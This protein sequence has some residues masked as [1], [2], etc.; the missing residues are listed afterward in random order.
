MRPLFLTS[1]LFFIGCNEYDLNNNLGNQGTGNDTDE[2]FGPDGDGDCGQPDLSAGSVSVDEECEQDEVGNFNPE[3]SWHNNM[4]GDIYY[5]PVVGQLTDDNDDGVRD[6]LD[7]PDIVV[8]NTYAEVI[9]LSGDDGSILWTFQASGENAAPALADLDEDGWM[10]VVVS[11]SYQ[12]VALNG[13]DGTTFWSAQGYMGHLNVAAGG[14]AIHDL[15]A[16]GTPEVIVG[17]RI[18]NGLTGAT[19]GQGSYGEGGGFIDTY[20]PIPAAADLDQ[21]G[22]MEVVV[23]NAA[24]N[25]DGSAMWYNG[26]IDGFP[27]I[28]N[29]DDDDNGE[30][31]TSRDGTVRLLDDDG[32][33]LWTYF[34]G[35]PYSGPPTVAD[36]DGDGGAEI[37]VAMQNVYVVLDEDGSAVWTRPTNDYSSGYTGSSVFDFE[38]DGRAEV[39]YAD[40]QDLW[41]FDGQTGAVKLQFSEHDSATAS[42]YPVIADIDGNG[43]ADIVLVSGYYQDY[44]NGVTVITDADQS[45]MPTRQIWNQHAYWVTNVNDDGTIPAHP[46]SNWLSF[47]TFRSGDLSAG[48][49]FVNADA[50]PVVLGSCTDECGEG[51]LD[52][53]LAVGNAGMEELPPGVA[54]SVYGVEDGVRTFLGSQ[55][56]EDSVASG[57]TSAGLWFELDVSGAA[58]ESLAV[59]ADDDDGPSS[60]YECDESNNQVTITDVCP[61]E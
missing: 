49:E 59:R 47:N 2:V 13:S 27:A 14:V 8:T 28:G 38:G 20:A 46:E 22:D 17:R 6:A 55:Y 26:L 16:D 34:G 56:T 36:F 3:V 50:V 53:V 40:E 33:V 48:G 4:V 43:H 61:V 24:Y 54:I 9:A 18:I 37:G 15:D 1:A 19:V 10:E 39:V 31:V 29:F 32:E 5:A 21:D 58:Y 45:W 57:D 41:V 12:T 42:E 11:N 30:V 44:Y 52:L 25:K 60:V 23:G 51:R 7:V 35:V